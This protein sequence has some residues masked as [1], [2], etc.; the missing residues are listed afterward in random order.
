[1]NL[2]NGRFEMVDF[3]VY[4]R[5]AERILSGSELYGIKED[6]HYVFKYAPNAGIYFIP[7]LLPPRASVYK[8]G[9]EGLKKIYSFQDHSVKVL[10]QPS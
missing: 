4:Y 10:Q 8:L 5:A 9:Y 1:M 3:E 6:G 2:V 7:F